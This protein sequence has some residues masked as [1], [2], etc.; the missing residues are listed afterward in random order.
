MARPQAVPIQGGAGRWLWAVA[1]RLGVVLSLSLLG[2]AL[3]GPGAHGPN[4]EHGVEPAVAAVPGGQQ[5]PRI[6]SATERHELVG[7]LLGGEL[8]LHIDRFADNEPVLGA[9]VEV[10]SGGIKARAVFH[11]DQGDYAVDD[12]ALL[13][14]LALPQAHKLR[15]TVRSASG[16]PEQEPDVLVGV[17]TRAQP[18][19]PLGDHDHDHGPAWRWWLTLG[20]LALAMGAGLGWR[21]RAGAARLGALKGVQP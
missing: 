8:S 16:G 7:R 3:A 17:L 12:P 9:W 20:L 14:W 13:K 19:T 1:S 18:A 21:R 11:A 2:P 6:E 10:E 4:G 5:W 15:I